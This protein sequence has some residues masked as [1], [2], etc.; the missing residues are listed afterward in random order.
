[1]RYLCITDIN[2]SMTEIGLHYKSMELFLYDKDLRHERVK[3]NDKTRQKK[4]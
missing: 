4:K 1:M 3:Y 2:F